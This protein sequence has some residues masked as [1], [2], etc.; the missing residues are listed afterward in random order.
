MNKENH[1]H[2]GI[3]TCDGRCLQNHSYPSKDNTPEDVNS[4]IESPSTKSASGTNSQRAANDTLLGSSEKKHADTYNLSSKML[5]L[6]SFETGWEQVIK[7]KD[8]REFVKK[9]NELLKMYIRSEISHLELWER[10]KKIAGDE[11]LK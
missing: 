8:V 3:H 5:Q 7:V 4:V 6:K 10:K 1:N 9:D 2:K 11:L